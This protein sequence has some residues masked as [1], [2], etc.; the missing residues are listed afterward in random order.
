MDAFSR[1]LEGLNL[2]SRQ[3]GGVKRENCQ[4]TNLQLFQILV[5][6]PF[7]SIKRFS[8]YPESAL[9]RMFNGKKD[10]FYEF[11]S[12]DN[13]DWRKVIYR[14]VVALIT[15]IT[16]RADFKRSH[17]PTVLIADDTDLPKSGMKIENIGKVFS[18][19]EQKCIL[20]FKALMLCWSDG[21]TQLMV[22]ASLHG[23]AGKV[24]GKEQGLTSKQRAERYSRERDKDSQTSK[25]NEE[26][27][28]AKGDELIEMVKRAVKRR[29]PFEYLLVDSWFTCSNLVDFVCRRHKK[30]HLLG[31]AKMGNTKYATGKWGELTA[32]AILRKLDAAKSV[33][34]CRRYR[35]RYAVCDAALGGHNVRLFFCRRGK[36]DKWRVLLTTD[37]S[38]DFLRAYEIYAMRWS[39]EVF[40]ADSKRV[41]G[42]SDCSARDFSSQ[43]AHVS[44]TIIRYDLLAFI[45]RAHDYETIGG[46]FSDIYCGVQELTVVEKIWGIILEVIAVVAEAT[47]ADE[48]ILILQIIENDKRFAALKAYAEAA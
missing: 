35:C 46:L 27:F 29:I 40:F 11:M 22:D 5:L 28:K 24:E 9:N 20:G 15:R 1:L 41:L 3:L 26:Y 32:N 18:H 43:I 8:H 34:A 12:Q 17:L 30:F 37:T 6:M 2:D 48:D 38:L 42:L 7:F 39:I 13:V 14:I 10:L 23:E 4:L 45:K 36:S 19:V 21:R 44:L 47:G 25:R 33:K 16:V 31:M